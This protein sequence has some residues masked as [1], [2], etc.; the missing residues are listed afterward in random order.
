MAPLRDVPKNQPRQVA[1]EAVYQIGIILSHALTRKRF[2][3]RLKADTKLAYQHQATSKALDILTAPQ[4]AEG[5]PVTELS[6]EVRNSYLVQ[7][8]N[9]VPPDESPPLISEADIEAAL[10]ELRELV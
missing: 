9:L 1:I 3:A 5:A 8:G 2:V 10:R 4:R 7:L 6:P